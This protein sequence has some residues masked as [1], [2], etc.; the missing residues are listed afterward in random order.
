MSEGNGLDLHDLYVNKV[1]KHEDYRKLSPGENVVDEF[2]IISN[3]G[4]GVSIID[5]GCGT[6]RASKKLHDSI[7]HFDVTMVD[8]AENCLD[9]EVRELAQ[10]NDRLRFIEHDITQKTKLTA[11]YGFCVD[12][13]E[14]LREDSIDDTIEIILGA[15]KNVFFQI[16]CVEDIF[17]QREEI[18]EDLHLTVHDYQWWLEKFAEHKVI[19]HRSAATSNAVMFYLTGWGSEA[20][21]F[22][23][24]HVNTPI[25]EIKANMAENSKL[26]KKG[27]TN[28]LPHEPQ[29]TEIMLLGGGPTLNDFIEDIIE[30]RAGG[31]PLVTTN[32]SFNW[33]IE[34]EL[35]P[36]LQ[37]VIDA[38]EHNHRFTT[39]KSPYTDNTK[40]IIASQCHPSVFDDLP[41]DRTYI[42]Q[43]SI[44]PELVDH[45]TE[46]YGEQYKDWYP[47]PGGSTVMLRAFPLLRS[48]GYHKIHVYGFDSCVFR[49][50]HH[51]AYPQKE[52]DGGG[53]LEMTVAGETRLAKE[54]LCNPWM[55]YQATEFKLMATRLL[56]DVDLI[57]YGDGMIAYMINS[58]AE[59]SDEEEDIP[60]ISEKGDVG[61]VFYA[62]Q[63]RHGNIVL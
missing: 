28:V 5:W 30:K 7:G 58:A 63:D 43:V 33:A 46:Y 53:P 44:S 19:I 41:L 26:L 31:M 1:W 39:L 6:G 32:G 24:G 20:F 35:N 54:F 47:M 25:K 22:D 18:D 12:V 42:W 38:R 4:K 36:S 45:A 50:K 60:D 27:A 17:G 37:L 8:F 9:D 59:L 34:H 2:L 55:V 3:P 10:D 57:V 56:S 14:H 49:D 48:L 40:F 62:P 13:M 16:S 52:N 61:A 11:Q 29:D 23:G 21:N 51:H 15:C